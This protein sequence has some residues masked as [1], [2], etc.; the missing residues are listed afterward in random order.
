[1]M[2][3]FAQIIGPLARSLFGEPNPAFS[4]E[5]EWRYGARGSLSVD[6]VNGRWFDHEVGE[7]GGVL[8][9]VT[10]ETKLTGPERLD[11]LERNGFAFDAIRPNGNGA[12]HSTIVAAYDYQDEGGGLLF[13]VCRFEPKDFRQRRPNGN[14]GW[15]WSVKGVRHVPY[16]LQQ[17][18]ETDDKVIC[19]VEGEKSA[20]KLWKIGIPATCSPGGAGKWR[21]ELNEFF[22]GADVVVIPD[23]DPQKRHPKTGELLFHPDGRPILPGQDHGQAV[24]KS[25]SDVATRVRVL[26]LWKHWPE[27]PLKADVYDWIAHGGT[28]DKLYALIDKTPDWTPPAAESR[29]NGPETTGDAPKPSI[30][31]A[32][33][34]RWRDPAKIPARQWLYA[35]HYARQFLTCTIAASGMGKTSLA[36]GEALAMASGKPLLGITPPERARVWLWN[37]EDPRDELD[38]RIVAAMLHYDLK[39]ADVEGY[40]FTDTGREM[41]VIIATQTRQGAIIAKPVVDAV[42]ATIRQNSIDVLVVDPFI[43]SHRVTE[44]DNSAMDAVATEWAHIADATN[45]AIELLHHTRKTGGAE[46]SVEDGRGAGAVVS[47][48]RSARTVNRMNKDEAEKAGIDATTAWRY[49]KVDSGKASMSSHPEHADWYRLITEPLGNGDD[50]GVVVGWSWPDAFAGVTVHDL[51]AAQKAVSEGGPWRA[52]LRATAWVGK[53]I[54]KA[55]KLN[56]KDKA[57]RQKIKTL[58][59]TW[60][61]T[62]MFVEVE[63]LGD[64]RHAVMFVE[65]GTW[66]ND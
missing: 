53:P 48:S 59:K 6:L 28:A 26:E 49:L 65:V 41:P 9:L 42:I 46:V 22:R 62:G 3:E 4:S 30:I 23:H 29:S 24:A 44:N 38:R 43:K 17:L 64:D 57:D 52:D 50:V 63:G 18:L 2:T 35:R 13:Q 56:I 11:W 45:C 61:D 8:D 58:L 15:V 60:I 40:L 36:I 21:E 16:R 14:G 20:D 54:A 66:A 31:S 51:R 7:G 55:L 34:F 39:P 37:G 12:A 19:I 32:T 47:A 27:M 5:H 25:L 10:R 1:M 33:P